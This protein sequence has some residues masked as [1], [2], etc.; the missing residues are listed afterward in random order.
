MRKIAP[1]QDLQSFQRD[2]QM[3]LLAVSH[4]SDSKISASDLSHVQKTLE[5]RIEGLNSLFQ[6]SIVVLNEAIQLHAYRAEETQQERQ[7]K[8]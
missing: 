6:S 5:Q 8:I 1:L 7:N 2:V 4:L 3:K